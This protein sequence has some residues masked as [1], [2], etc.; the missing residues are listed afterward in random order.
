[1]KPGAKAGV[2]DNWEENCRSQSKSWSK[3]PID[4]NENIA[5]DV[6]V[7]PGGEMDKPNWLENADENDLR[8]L[9]ANLSPKQKKET[10]GHQKIVKELLSLY[11]IDK[12][13]A[14]E[15][16]DEGICLQDVLR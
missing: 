3:I 15:W 13:T 11:N 9:E 7:G 2:P 6:V 4:N 10:M 5:A 14:Q 8:T 12:A 16:E 1:M